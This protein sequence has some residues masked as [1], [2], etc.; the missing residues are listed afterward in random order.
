MRVS[1]RP[2][3]GLPVVPLTAS[4]ALGVPGLLQVVQSVLAGSLFL[5]RACLRSARTTGRYYGISKG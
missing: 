4:K 3:L 5:L 1:S 2:E